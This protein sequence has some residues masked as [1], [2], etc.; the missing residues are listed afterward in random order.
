M[1]W[2]IL[3]VIFLTIIA[4]IYYNRHQSVEKITPTEKYT[5]YTDDTTLKTLRNMLKT[6]DEIFHANGITYWIDGG[7]LLGAVRHHDVIP[8]DDDGD[9]AVFETHESKLLSAI[10]DFRNRGYGVVKTWHGYKIY[11]LNGK[12]IKPELEYLYPFVDI[13]FVNK[14]GDHYHF[15]DTEVQDKWPNYYHDIPDLFPLRRYQFASFEL[16]GPNNAIPYLNR[17]YG[18]N[19]RKTAIKS[20]DHASESSIDE[21]VFKI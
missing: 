15:A 10:P 17:A 12:S 11:P 6:T 3:A 1:I 2:L 13:F 21:I 5:I 7:T 8:W 16:T 19:W 4:Y 14:N 18:T 20:Y 9:L